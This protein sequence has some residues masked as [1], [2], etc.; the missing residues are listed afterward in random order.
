VLILTS[1]SKAVV[2]TAR[3][4]AELASRLADMCCPRSCREYLHRLVADLRAVEHGD[5]NKAS[6]AVRKAI[7]SILGGS[8]GGGVGSESAGGHPGDRETTAGSPVHRGRSRSRSDSP[9]C[10]QSTNPMFSLAGPAAGSNEGG[11]WFAGNSASG[12]DSIS[13][14]GSGIELPESRRGKDGAHG[15]VSRVMYYAKRP[16]TAA[17]AK[18]TSILHSSSFGPVTVARAH[19]RIVRDAGG[20][21]GDGF[22][23]KAKF[24]GAGARSVADGKPAAARRQMSSWALPGSRAK[25]NHSTGSASPGDSRT[26]AQRSL[27]RKLDGGQAIGQTHDVSLY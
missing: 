4:L 23:S 17:G 7:Q 6:S 27:A 14:N 3:R 10:T 8:G 9:S 15:G 16:G 20:A 26:A 1:S 12:R 18:R 21:R 5:T 25:D 13:D 11:P 2:K 19:T 22:A 24:T